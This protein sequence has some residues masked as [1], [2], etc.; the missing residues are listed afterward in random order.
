MSTINQNAT[1]GAVSP[2]GRNAAQEAT[3][4]FAG[5]SGIDRRVRPGTPPSPGKPTALFDIQN[6][7]VLHGGT[8]EKRCGFRCPV[9]ISAAIRAAASVEIDGQEYLYCVAGSGVYRIDPEDGAERLLTLDEPTGRAVF[10]KDSAGLLLLTSSQIFRCGKRGDPD[11]VTDAAYIPLYLDGHNPA[12]VAFSQKE[13]L[14]LLSDKVR[15]SYRFAVA[16]NDICLPFPLE[17]I[18][19]LTVDGKTSQ[20]SYTFGVSEKGYLH[21]YLAVPCTAGQTLTI[22]CVPAGDFAPERRLRNCPAAQAMRFGGT[23]E[24]EER[25][26]FAGSGGGIYRNRPGYTPEHG[27]VYVTEDDFAD[28]VTDGARILGMRR[29]FDR[30]LCFTRNATWRVTELDGSLVFGLCN[31]GIGTL[32]PDAVTAIGNAPVT[33]M[34]GGVWRFTDDTDE[35]RLDNAESLSDPLGSLY[36]PDG[37]TLFYDSV[38]RELWLRDPGDE[39]G[40]AY[41]YDTAGGN[42]YRFTGIMA[43]GFFLFEGRVGYFGQGSIFLSDESARADTRPNGTLAEIFS[44]FETHWFGFGAG[45]PLRRSGTLGVV[46]DRDM[47]KPTWE[48]LGECS[49]RAGGTMG[50]DANTYLG[51]PELITR[52]FDT[53]R[54][55]YLKLWFSSG[56]TARPRIFGMYV[57]ARK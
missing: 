1:N 37:A 17:R 40:T 29:H 45:D 2:I 48:I 9:T 6:L 53:A 27:G 31:G 19:S 7:R 39:S 46:C 22:T 36:F 47:G 14:N 52:G 33:V 11:A 24:G 44:Y 15:L 28:P 32:S 13:P 25:L 50:G 49:A 16:G 35:S 4:Q 38:R 34:G 41:V 57:S 30:L 55:R 18:L 3:V 51:A 20:I 21:M 26:F 10:F 23:P 12:S 5:F 54:F 43:D 42:W 56:G 8:L